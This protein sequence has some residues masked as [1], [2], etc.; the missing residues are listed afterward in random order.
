MQGYADGLG[1]AAT[2]IR[3]LT[4]KVSAADAATTKKLS[5]SFILGTGTVTVDLTTATA[6]GLL[7]KFNLSQ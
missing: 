1:S 4:Q 7:T 2:Q 3:R 6:D 5:V